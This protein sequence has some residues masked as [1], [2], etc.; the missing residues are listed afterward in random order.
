MNNLNKIFEK[1]IKDTFQDLIDLCIECDETIKVLNLNNIKSSIRKN[2]TP[3]ELVR[4][5]AQC[6]KLEQIFLLA[7]ELSVE[8]TPKTN[9][10]EDWA[11][12]LEDYINNTLVFPTKILNKKKS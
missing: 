3:R 5:S 11:Y 1:S 7:D 9:S 12:L 6:G 4:I 2:A 8:L 10:L